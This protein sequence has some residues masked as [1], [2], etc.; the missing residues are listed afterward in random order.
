MTKPPLQRIEEFLDKGK[1]DEFWE[2]QNHEDIIVVYQK[3]TEK[4]EAALRKAI[5]FIESAYKAE[6][7]TAHKYGAMY[8]EEI[9]NILEGKEE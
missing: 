6:Q 5:E 7:E 1:F 2:K 4:L 9:S 8:L 3:R